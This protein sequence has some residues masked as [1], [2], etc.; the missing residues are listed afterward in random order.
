M[1][2]TYTPVHETTR[3]FHLSN[4]FYRWLMGPIGCLPG[5]SE[6]LT[7]AGWK[8]M[9]EY[10]A[11]DEVAVWDPQTGKVAFERARPVQLPAVGFY[12]FRHPRG[13][14]SM[15]LSPEHTVAA[16]DF[17]G[18]FKTL[19]ARRL[20][21]HPSKHTIPTT[22][23]LDRP[24]A[25]LTDELIRLCVM[26]A[27]DGHVPSAGRK[28][29]V[30]VRKDRKVERLQRLLDA[31]GV[32]HTHTVR[33]Q[34]PEEHIFR[35]EP[36]VGLR[37]GLDFVWSLSTRQL[38]VVLDE[39]DH[40]DGLVEHAE[41]R[42]YTTRLDEAQAVQFAAHACGL[43]ATIGSTQ[44]PRQ[45]WSTNYTVY[46]RR[47]GSAKNRAMVR[48][49][50]TEIA[51]RDAAPGE[52][53]YCFQTSTGFFVARHDATVFVTGNCGKSFAICYEILIRAA[54]QAPHADT[55][56]RRTKVLFV[57][58]TR[59]QLI[60]SCLPI[61][62]E[63][64]PE[65]VL[66]SWRSSDSVYQVRTGDIECDILLR[67]LEDEKDVKRV[68][69][70]NASFVVF[71]EWRELP[72]GLI[73]Q[74]AARGGRFPAKNEEGCTFAGAFGASNPPVEDSDW[75]EM[76][77]NKRPTNTE[78]FKFPSARSPEATWRQF[79]REG[80]YEDLADGATEDFI[81]VMIDGEYGRS[82]AG[83]A[84]FEKTFVNDFHV[85]R[86]PLLYLKDPQYPLC[87]GMDFGRTPSAVVTQRDARGR[88]LVLSECSE[89]NMGLETF[90]RDVFKPHMANAYPGMAYYVVGDPAGWAK[91][92]LSEESV[93][94]V[95]ARQRIAAARAP[96]N[97]PERRIRAVEQVLLYQAD[98]RALFL[99]DPRCKT[100]IRALRGGY[101][102]RR[103]TD[104]TYEPKPAKDE[105]SHIADACQYA[106]LGHDN[107]VHARATRAVE[108]D[109]LPENDFVP[110]AAGWT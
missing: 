60:D 39:L 35:F 54:Q 109:R 107:M 75:Y 101:K 90:L 62:Q 57:R 51:W 74:V 88:L 20:A 38:R 28:V 99:I 47:E 40:W 58:N 3:Q 110:A 26:F 105:H 103:K 15:E 108:R 77:E 91:S 1:N 92:Q 98:G 24:D 2:I 21:E 12:S 36:P 61:L 86:E 9:D 8:R 50:V 43:R 97:D 7:P 34:R 81:R 44:S 30:T 76:L 4:A 83:R 33:S 66:G 85:A 70:V 72:T 49:D 94:D 80:Y 19:T 48:S 106:V 104:G 32:E 84:V 100:L 41:K 65:G 13:G 42:F 45:G 11:G 53:Q 89:Q 25:P 68:L 46:I 79:L 71:D 37:K 5:R 59:Q 96:T 22:F 64:F 82:V 102:Y 73:R 69:S 52:Q 17:A 56:K 95:F 63:V 78:V 29:V 31:A 6:F 16:Y 27:A 10:E 67:P 93:K 18:K 87:V 23:E 14:L 55:G